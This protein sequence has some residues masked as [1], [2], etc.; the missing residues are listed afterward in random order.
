[1][2]SNYFASA[3]NNSTI[4][5]ACVNQMHTTLL[6]HWPCHHFQQNLLCPPNHGREFEKKWWG[7]CMA[8]TFSVSMRSAEVLKLMA[9]PSLGCRHKPA[10]QWVNDWS[11]LKLEAFYYLHTYNSHVFHAY[12]NVHFI[13]V[14]SGINRLTCGGTATH[15]SRSRLCITPAK[16]LCISA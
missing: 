4:D 16:E 3:L 15:K 2:D 10:G 8:S 7:T 5:S 6:S 13:L 12:F 14:A 1:M 11:P 9:K